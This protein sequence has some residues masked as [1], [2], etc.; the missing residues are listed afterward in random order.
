MK[1]YL[2]YVYFRF[3]QVFDPRTSRWLSNRQNVIATL[4]DFTIMNLERVLHRWYDHNA[5][6]YLSEDST[7]TKTALLFKNG[8][9]DGKGICKR[10]GNYYL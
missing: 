7:L 3:G 10:R 9:Y 6:T 4:A 2:G 1:S 5:R 8:K